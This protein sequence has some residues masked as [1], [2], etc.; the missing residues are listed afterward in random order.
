MSWMLFPDNA[1]LSAL[2]LG[3]IAVVFLYAAR[4]PVHGMLTA[5]SRIAAGGLRVGGHWLSRAADG[6]RERNKLVLLAQARKGVEQEIQ[7]EFERITVMVRR[8]LG[9]YPVLQRRLLDEITRVEDD[10]KKC[11][12]VPPPPPDWVKA[13]ETIANIKNMG[14]PLTQKILEDIAKSLGPIYEKV[15]GE[16]RRSYEQRHKILAGFMP[17]WRSLEQTLAKVDANMAG[18]QDGA[19][20]IDGLMDRYQE[21]QKKSEK[22]E[23]SLTASASSQFFISGIVLAIALGGAFVNFWLIQR[24]M[25]AMVGAGEYIVGNLEVSHVAALVIIL[26]ES[27]MGLFLLEALRITHL[28]PGINAMHD[29]MR[30]TLAWIFFTI[31]FVLA[32]VEVG[33]AVMRDQIILADMAFKSSLGNSAGGVVAQAAADLGW[34]QKVPVAGQMILGFILPFALAFVGLPLEYFIHSARTVIG[35]LL[36]FLLRMLSIALRIASNVFRHLGKAMT[37]LFDAL[38]FLPL[39]VERLIKSRGAAALPAPTPTPRAQGRAS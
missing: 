18:M 34:V 17:F 19:A 14:D 36:V 32:G 11:G 27:A 35:A 28:F 13:T 39:S 15:V 20:R 25:S 12:E 7:R 4:T 26:I 8:D 10:Y 30:R 6:L 23:H 21:I 3:L 31:L 2:V 1:A 16:Y 29:K 9:G 33:L 5:V 22:V 37:M 38:I 24:P